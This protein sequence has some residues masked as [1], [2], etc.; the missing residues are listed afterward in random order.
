[1]CA[2]S[3]RTSKGRKNLPLEPHAQDK[4][5]TRVNSEEGKNGE[6]ADPGRRHNRE[7]Q[8]LTSSVTKR[9]SSM[10]LV[11]RLIEHDLWLTE[12]LLA[13]AQALPDSALDAPIDDHVQGLVVI[14]EPTLRQLFEAMVFTKEMWGAGMAGE[15]IARSQASSAPDL[16]A[17]CRTAAERFRGVVADIQCR[18]GWDE[19]FIR[20]TWSPPG[21]FTKGGAVAHTL[22]FSACRRALALRVLQSHCLGMELGNDDPI[23]WEPMAS[24]Q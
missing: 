19:T 16:L 17:R 1:M 24:A 23:D 5:H 7:C 4:R 9:G 21:I 15:A 10:D 22:T 14:A 8:A 13:C 11:Q 18:N 12:R 3:E 6:A 2:S 20:T